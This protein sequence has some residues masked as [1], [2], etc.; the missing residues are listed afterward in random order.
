MLF[1]GVN[2]TDIFK[3]G[4]EY[5][6]LEKDADFFCIIVYEYSRSASFLKKA[7]KKDIQSTLEEEKFLCAIENLIRIVKHHAGNSEKSKQVI[8]SIIN[9]TEYYYLRC[10][11]DIR[12]I[13]G[14]VKDIIENTVYSS[15]KTSIN[16]YRF[17]SNDERIAS[18][19]ELRTILE[20]FMSIMKTQNEERE[21][22][23]M[24]Q[25]ERY[26]YEHN[27]NITEFLDLYSLYRTARDI[28]SYAY[29]LI[30]EGKT[31]SDDCKEKFLAPFLD[32]CRLHK[33]SDLKRIKKQY[34]IYVKLKKEFIPK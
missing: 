14:M 21:V 32:F 30:G 33:H 12:Y 25:F 10:I 23:I 28:G 13:E 26:V 22:E 11:T 31:N 27:E 29:E 16:F 3:D 8:E 1:F 17:L 34:H 20:N 19:K 24:K 18:F 6:I 4:K 15:K 7:R 9:A 2:D 5:A